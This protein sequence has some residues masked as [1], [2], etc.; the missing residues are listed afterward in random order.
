M[1]VYTHIHDT[2][3]TYAGIQYFWHTLGVPTSNRKEL[4]NVQTSALQF[5]LRLHGA[6]TIISC[7]MG[8]WWRE[9]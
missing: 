2:D 8:G 6:R 3:C 4:K 9:S 5:I 7:S 1:H